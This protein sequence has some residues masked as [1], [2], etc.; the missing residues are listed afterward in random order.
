M[1]KQLACKAVQLTFSL[2]A[3]LAVSSVLWIGTRRWEEKVDENFYIRRTFF[4]ANL[5][6]Q[7]CF[8]SLD[9]FG[10]MNVFAERR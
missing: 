1:Q 9:R 7:T 3:D 6:N 2:E 5:E 10:Q 4:K 8:R